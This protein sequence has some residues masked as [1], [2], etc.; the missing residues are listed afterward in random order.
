MPDLMISYSRID[1]IFVKRL[2]AQLQQ[3]GLE[4]WVDYHRI[5]YGTEW[6]NVIENGIKSS[7][8]LIVVLSPDW[9][10]SKICNE[11]LRIAL[12]AGKRIFPVNRRAVNDASRFKEFWDAQDWGKEASEHFVFLND[13]LNYI[14]MRK[15]DTPESI[16]QPDSDKR[17]VNPS[18]DDPSCDHP[19]DPFEQR[20]EALVGSLGRD[21][22][23]SEQ[24]TSL[25]VR[26]ENWLTHQRA[27]G[28]LLSIPELSSYA[29]WIRQRR[30][31]RL[32][33]P[34]L[35]KLQTEYIA[36][37]QR[38]RLKIIRNL[39]MSFIIVV[40]VVIV[41]L[42]FY[43]ISNATKLYFAGANLKASPEAA[44]PY[45][46]AALR[47]DGRD[48]DDSRPL[49]AQL[50]IDYCETRFTWLPGSDAETRWL[51]LANACQQINNAT[52]ALEAYAKAKQ[53]NGNNVEPFLQSAAIFRTQ[54]EYQKALD[55]LKQILPYSTAENGVRARVQR[56]EAIVYYDQNDCEQA[57]G[58]L[59]DLMPDQFPLDSGEEMLFYRAMCF[60]K[61]N[62][63]QSA[64]ATWREYF[65]ILQDSN[66]YADPN[67]GFPKREAEA[68]KSFQQ[69]PK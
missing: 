41:I 5:D 44:I 65:P 49:S 35:T 63:P 68:R 38:R 47:M 56:E 34:E 4:V 33:L 26:A 17:I 59:R 32:E 66:F 50:T 52:C 10:R 42:Y 11:E 6:R 1:Q 23:D 61:T 19:S 12:G 20:V 62:N 21:H 46:C 54:G 18:C 3:H 53:T 7:N 69:C 39:V 37:S 22:E 29:R 14:Q 48:L 58:I 24:H 45:Y 60:V 51:A 67:L 36:A 25:T 28:F 55:L 31:S 13:K 30:S 43:L 64:C 40:S 16:C 9:H 27:S 8:A 15:R 57:L 2:A